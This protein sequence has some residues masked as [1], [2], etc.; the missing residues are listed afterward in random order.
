VRFEGKINIGAS[1]PDVWAFLTDANAVS[2][3]MPGLESIEII[4]PNE[5]FRAVGAL[6]LGSVKLKMNTDVEWVELDAPSRAKMRMRGTAPGS[7]IDV[8]SEMH[9]ADGP[10]GSTDMEWSAEVKILGTVASLAA[11]LMKPVTQKLTGEFF[12]CVKKKMEK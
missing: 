4:T 12:N 9:L 1:R 3:C 5:K 10:G 6:G 8:A 11:R 2:H 7:S